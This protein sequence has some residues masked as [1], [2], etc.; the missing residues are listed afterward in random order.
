MMEEN[1]DLMLA[2]WTNR[3]QEEIPPDDIYTTFAIFIEKMDEIMDTLYRENKIF[4]HDL[5][6]DDDTLAFAKALCKINALMRA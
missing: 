2:L 3:L 5:I 6:D 1:E 4:Y